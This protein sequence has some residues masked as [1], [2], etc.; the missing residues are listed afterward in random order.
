MNANYV[1]LMEM[2]KDA[3]LK[4]REEHK[5]EMYTDGTY[6]PGLTAKLSKRNKTGVKGVRWDKDRLKWAASI[7]FK[8]KC[9]QLGRFDNIEDAIEARKLAEEKLFKPLLKEEA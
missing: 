3:E 1:Y 5:Q 9:Y 4:R 2:Q 8:G 6:I 7:Y